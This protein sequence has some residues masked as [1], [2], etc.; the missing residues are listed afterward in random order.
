M[1]GIEELGFVV[2]VWGVTSLLF[3]DWVVKF[4]LALRERVTG[5]FFTESAIEEQR[6]LLEKTGRLVLAAGLV[7]F[8]AGVAMHL[9]HLA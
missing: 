4:D 1:L 2:V 6:V 8:A 7:V 9:A 3:R 5:D